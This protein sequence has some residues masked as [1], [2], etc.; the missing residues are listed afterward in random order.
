M[1]YVTRQVGGNVFVF[2]DADGTLEFIPKSTVAEAQACNIPV[3][4]C[5]AKDPCIITKEQACWEQ[6]GV[7]VFTS[8]EISGDGANLVL[9]TAKKSYKCKRDANYMYFTNG[10]VV[11]C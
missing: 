5:S 4:I 3:K 10:I 9:K 8:G 6:A 1:Y 11:R 2:N 7:S